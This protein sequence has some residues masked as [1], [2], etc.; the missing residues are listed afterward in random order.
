MQ[1]RNRTPTQGSPRIRPPSSGGYKDKAFIGDSNANLKNMIIAG[2]GCLVVIMFFMNGGNNNPV[3]AGTVSPVR[4]AVETPDVVSDG[5]KAAQK[6]AAA[7]IKAQIKA[8]AKKAAQEEHDNHQQGIEEAHQKAMEQK[9][10]KGAAPLNNNAGG[11]KGAKKQ[12]V[13]DKDGDIIQDDM[14]AKDILAG[15]DVDVKHD[16]AEEENDVPAGDD[17]WHQSD[18]IPKWLKDYFDW[19]KKT[20]AGLTKENWR[21][22]R[23]LAMTCLGGE[24]CG[25]VAHRLRP[26]MAML[27]IAA[28]S[29]RVFYIHWD[30]P[31]RLEKFLHP[32]AHGGINWTIPEFVMWK[33]RKSPHQNK[34]DAIVHQV[35]QDDRRVVNVMYNDDSFAEPYYNDRLKDGEV[36]ASQA[37]HDVWNVLFKPSFMLTER[38]F[39][40]LRLMGLKPGEY[41][42]AHIDYEW[43]PRN[44][45]EQE[46]LRLKVENAMNCMSQLR[47]GGPFLV[48]AQT[49]AIA[50]KPLCMANSTMLWSMPNRLL[51][52]LLQCLLI[53]SLLLWK[54]CSWPILAVWLTIVVD[55]VSWVIFWDMITIVASSIPDRKD[56]SVSGRIPQLLLWKKPRNP[57]TMIPINKLSDGGGEA[58]EK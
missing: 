54:F 22:Q 57:N 27:R 6:A 35:S 12:V 9:G 2:L 11:V 1:M 19:H 31:D 23:Y 55:M 44:D 14:L 48:A 47:P 39:E 21:D 16:E 41:A 37:F 17:R 20:V 36:P 50:Q 3:P 30:L 29:K 51:T 7:D 52:I 4:R 45:A 33:V 10:V 34:L 46:E 56:R 5:N 24:I 43:V 26:M 13:R 58:R 25:N 8:E 38:I 40:S 18:T 49:Y 53:C 42:T 15:R 28:D 32:P